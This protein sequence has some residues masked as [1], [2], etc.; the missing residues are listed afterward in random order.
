MFLE[1]LMNKYHL[2]SYRSIFNGRKYYIYCCKI[3]LN[4]IL[5]M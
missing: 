4:K 1:K 5:R 3:I 2:I